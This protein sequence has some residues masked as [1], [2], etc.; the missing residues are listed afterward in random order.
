MIKLYE[1]KYVP[2]ILMSKNKLIQPTLRKYR[3]DFG[4]NKLTFN[5]NWF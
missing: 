2:N 4:K 1:V 5:V 3:N